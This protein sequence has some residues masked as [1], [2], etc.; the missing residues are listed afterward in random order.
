MGHVLVVD[1]AI[2]T[3]DRDCGSEITFNFLRIVKRLNWRITF[4]PR[5]SKGS[6][7]MLRGSNDSACDVFATP[8]FPHLKPQFSTRGQKSTLRFSTA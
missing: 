1:A 4:I 7:I 3:P 5:I 2:P 8:R 6:T